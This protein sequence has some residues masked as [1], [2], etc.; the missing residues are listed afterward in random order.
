MIFIS[1][2]YMK[3]NSVQFGFFWNTR[4][5]EYKPRAYIRKFTVFYEISLHKHYENES[6][7]S[8]HFLQILQNVKFTNLNL[9]S[10]ITPVR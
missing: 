2:R 5:N 8:K 10:V 7:P 1:L 9:N 4:G 6:V 3:S